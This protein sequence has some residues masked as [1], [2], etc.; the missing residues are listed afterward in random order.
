[1]SNSSFHIYSP[2]FKPWAINMGLGWRWDM[3]MDMELGST[4]EN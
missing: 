2:R 3:G 4:N 1:M